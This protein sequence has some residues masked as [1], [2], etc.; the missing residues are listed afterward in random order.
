MSI[1][2]SNPGPEVQRQERQ[3]RRSGLSIVNAALIVL[4]GLIAGAVVSKGIGN[5]AHFNVNY[6]GIQ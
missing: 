1:T 2:R 6:E 4:I 5:L 3:Y